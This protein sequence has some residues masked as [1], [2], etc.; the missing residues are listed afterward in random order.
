MVITKDKLKIQILENNH[1]VR[2]TRCTPSPIVS[3]FLL[4]RQV[5]PIYKRDL[6]DVSK[7]H[8]V[9]LVRFDTYADLLPPKD[10][11][12]DEAETLHNLAKYDR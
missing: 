12:A 10:V 7:A 3:R 6:E 9:A 1:E 5:L 8:E 4:S 11:Q 2:T